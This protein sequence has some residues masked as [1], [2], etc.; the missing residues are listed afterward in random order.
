MTEAKQTCSHCSLFLFRF[1]RHG[2][3]S[4]AGG[5]T[6]EVAHDAVQL[7]DSRQRRQHHIQRH[8]HRLPVFVRPPDRPGIEPP[9]QQ[10]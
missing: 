8:H 9:E 3:R 6:S 2:E 1:A 5:V 7:A 4:A 10:L